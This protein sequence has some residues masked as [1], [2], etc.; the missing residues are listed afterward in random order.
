[1]QARYYDPAVGRFLSVDPLG[2]IDESMSHFNRYTYSNNNPIVNIDPDGRKVVVAGTGEFK[3][4]IKKQMSE[5]RST[6]TGR[7]LLR[8]LEESPRIFAVTENKGSSN[9]T[10]DNPTN[11]GN[12]IG[13]SGEIKHDPNA[14]PIVNTPDGPKATPPAVV[15]GHE[16]VHAAD[17]DDGTLDK[18]VNPDTGT[19]RSEEKAVHEENKI[20]GE[21]ELP[22][23]SGY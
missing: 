1:M 5:L 7:S 2:P 4:E 18:T 22:K 20:R 14:T 11:A 8:S 19:K 10:P 13:S 6:P 12:H 16:L 17:F 9:A 3:R 21:M 23:R 15:L